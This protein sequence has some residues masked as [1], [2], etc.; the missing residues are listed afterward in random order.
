MSGESS[1]RLKAGA[2]QSQDSTLSLSSHGSQQRN[3]RS[4]RLLLRRGGPTRHF[5]IPRQSRQKARAIRRMPAPR[6]DAHG[7]SPDSDEPSRLSNGRSAGTVRQGLLRSV[8]QSNRSVPS[9][10]ES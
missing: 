3:L 8:G 5:A 1:Q 9:D 6:G 7:G 10:R 4:N 2:E